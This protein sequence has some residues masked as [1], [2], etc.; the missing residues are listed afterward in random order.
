[1]NATTKRKS[2]PTESKRKLISFKMSPKM[3]A[4]LR[5]ESKRIGMTMT[6]IVERSVLFA[7]AHPDFQ[8]LKPIIQ[9]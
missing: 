5:S 7:S 8:I 3:I 1:M 9:A 4:S 6:T 2:K